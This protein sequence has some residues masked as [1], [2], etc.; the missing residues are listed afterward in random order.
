MAVAARSAAGTSAAST[1]ARV[2]PTAGAPAV[3]VV[4][5]EWALVTSVAEVAPGVTRFRFRN[6]GTVAHAFRIRSAGSGKNRLEWRSEVVGPG[7]SADLLADLP[8]GTFE[9]D[10]PIEDAHGEHDALGMEA[11]LTVRPGAPPAP[12][13]AP[14]PAPASSA[15]TPAATASVAITAFAYAPSDLRVT[16]GTEVTWTNRDPASHT[17]TGDGFDTGRL[18]TGAAGS[19]R[20]DRPGT[21]TYLCT[22]HPAMTG[23]VV[24]DP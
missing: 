13:A 9:L 12:S 8:A 19:H 11:P 21:F 10:C 17:A 15:P 1:A 20:F 2:A 6:L 23:R 24:V 7:G 16:A 22:V 4:L 5:G 18:A 14:P 3:D